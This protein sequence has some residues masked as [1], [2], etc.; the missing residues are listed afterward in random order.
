[1]PRNLPNKR[2]YALQLQA[3]A[4]Y[5]GSA[6]LKHEACTYSIQ[7][8]DIEHKAHRGWKYEKTQKHSVPKVQQESFLQ[9]WTIDARD[10]GGKA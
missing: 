1:L 9:S 7:L 2:G 5:S 3:I 10:E 8:R 6:R 4:E